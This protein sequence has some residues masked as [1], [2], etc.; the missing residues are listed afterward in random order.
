[1]K[2]ILSVI[3]FCFLK[4]SYSQTGYITQISD[5]TGIGIFGSIG[6]L[7]QDANHLYV[8]VNTN[9]DEGGYCNGANGQ[10]FILK[11]DKTNGAIINSFNF[12]FDTM[13][14]K[15]NAGFFYNNCVY[16]GGQ[17]SRSPWAHTGSYI[18]KYNFLT[19]QLE[20]TKG[21]VNISHYKHGI[22]SLK[23]DQNNKWIYFSGN[24]LANSFS[25]GGYI[26][27]YIGII[28]TLGNNF[29]N[30]AGTIP[31]MENSNGYLNNIPVCSDYKIESFG[32]NGFYLI[33]STD[34]SSRHH[35]L[36]IGQF[37]APS[38]GNPFFY[39]GASGR[40]YSPDSIFSK[41]QFAMPIYGNK[42]TRVVS[43][44]NKIHADIS[45]NYTYNNCNH[46]TFDN[47]N[48][49]YA[50]SS[51]NRVFI[52]ATD[53]SSNENLTRNLITFE[54]DTTLNI[55]NSIKLKIDSIWA[56][57]SHATIL[58]STANSLYNVFLKK[59]FS[60]N[61]IYIQKINFGNTNCH[62]STTLISSST[63][64]LT[65]YTFTTISTNSLPIITY[66]PITNP[67]GFISEDACPFLSSYG[68]LGFV[69]QEQSSDYKLLTMQN[70]DFVI[71][72]PVNMKKVMVFNNVGQQVL[73]KLLND[74]RCQL[75][76]NNLSNGMYFISIT[77][78]YNQTKTFKVIKNE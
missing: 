13:V 49:K 7:D 36:S 59:G 27:G 69:N 31:T 76:L 14:S 71:E 75:S 26:G 4:I 22:Q 55:L 46:K 17:T 45:S 39:Y 56:S 74:S 23:L 66:N 28:D 19:Q 43:E 78:S 5:S 20:W 8:G 12:N 6:F 29:Y 54:L 61:H 48:L 15:I 25:F 47:L 52:T 53:S 34:I 42:I 67:K 32:S 38:S 65:A 9:Y 30:S 64:S 10:S 44:Q 51:H 2:Y 11:L 35:A 1:M 3:I 73:Y 18:S 40:S 72:C 60:D 33:S 24:E 77:D 50:Y 21:I 62:E 37:I 63:N 70:N 68:N 16:F 57:S 58:D 41:L